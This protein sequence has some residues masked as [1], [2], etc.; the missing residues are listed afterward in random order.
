MRLL[1]RIQVVA[2]LGALLAGSSLASA[3][4]ADFGRLAGT[5]NDTAGNPLAGATV[6]LQGPA[7]LDSQSLDASVE[8]VL[9]DTKGRFNI[10]HLAPGWYSLK[11]TSP[12][13]LPDSRSGI[14][15]EAGQT[16]R[17]SLILAD[18]FAPVH[19]I[20]P[21][22][23]SV[24]SMG[25]DW[26]WVLRT[27]A[28]TRP[29]LRY[30][31]RRKRPST[32]DEK[33]S[34]QKY[35]ASQRLVGISPGSPPREPLAGDRGPGSVL[36]YV[37]PLSEDSD[38]L[39]AGSMSASGGLGSSLV[40]QF[41]RNMLDGAPQELALVAHQLSFSPGLAASGSGPASSAQGF[42]ASY[43]TT[44]R[45]SDSLSLTSGLEVD[46]LNAHHSAATANPRAKL[47]YRLNNQTEVA[48]SYG[49][50]PSESSTLLE[51][52]DALN[53]FPRITFSDRAAHI[54]KVNHSEIAVERQIGQNS[55]LQ[56]AA[57]HDGF[58]DAAVW[59]GGI[60]SDTPRL[61]AGGLFLN[62][63]TSELTLNAGDYGSTGIRAVYS[64]QL[65]ES[66]EVAVVYALGE[67]LAMN[68][69]AS[70]EDI[71]KLLQAARSQS[72]GGKVAARLPR[73]RT[74]L[75]ASYQYLKQGR[76]T[77]IDPYGQAQAGLLPYLDLQIRQP[78]P[79]FAFFPAHLEALA[80]F[81]NL[82]AQGYVPVSRPGEDS[83]TLAPIYR[84]LRG[85]FSV[86]F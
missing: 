42:R 55:R 39:V 82:L 53:A 52:V 14:R 44:R 54:E 4:A 32:P 70:S 27:S 65:T 83:F 61:F 23:G 10:E 19:L 76:V 68:S 60:P 56:F 63:S 34:S 62:P 28:S 36:A 33:N 30:T 35:L 81:R 5:V 69:S 41:R 58:R 59:G 13:R 24:S 45:I 1:T 49:S 57:Y 22:E 11:V 86:Q 47:Q 26:K 31:D 2:L 48:V 74:Q 67:A 51:R 80:D 3:A 20:S 43:S 12:A 17:L 38:L 71:R 66:V 46:Y 15:V 64:R 72:V 40:T 9:T 25:Q 79:C 29:I 78:I 73:T 16:A 18:I 8:R 77:S 21:T 6:L 75:V 37:Q 85:G 84:S 50:A 7:L